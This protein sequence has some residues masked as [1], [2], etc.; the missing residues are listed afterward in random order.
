MSESQGILSELEHLRERADKVEDHI[1]KIEK[2]LSKIDKALAIANV[3]KKYTDQRFDALEGKISGVS[4][5]LQKLSLGIRAGFNRLL[6]LVG[7]LVIAA[8]WKFIVS[9]GLTGVF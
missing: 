1:S 2:E 6:W 8:F 4:D 7:S 5:E 3:D 9:G